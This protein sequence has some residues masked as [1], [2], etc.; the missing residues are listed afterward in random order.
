MLFDQ[1]QINLPLCYK[2]CKIPLDIIQSTN[3]VFSTYLPYTGEVR[4]IDVLNTLTIIKTHLHE[5][6]NDI[7]D[8]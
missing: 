2:L 5:S 8:T 3:L 4:I 7:R 6:R 1:L